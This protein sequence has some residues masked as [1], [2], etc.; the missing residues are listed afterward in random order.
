MRSIR[1]RDQHLCGQDTQ[2]AVP[3]HSNSGVHG[4][5]GRDGGPFFLLQEK[6]PLLKQRFIAELR[7]AL[8]SIGMDPLLYAVHSF[9]IGA[10][11]A[12]SQAGLPDSTIQ[13][14]G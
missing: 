14:L 8:N 7:N 11:T 9:R 13:A 2:P 4:N 1:E 3:S 12:A 10:A 6:N 5:V